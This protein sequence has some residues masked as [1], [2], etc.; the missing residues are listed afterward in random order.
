MIAIADNLCECGCGG[1]MTIAKYDDKGQ[2]YKAGKPRRFIHTHWQ[3]SQPKGP[4]DKHG[5]TQ[6]ER[7]KRS[8]S[9][10]HF[11]QELDDNVDSEVFYTM[12]RACW[13]EVTN[14]AISRLL[15]GVGRRE[16]VKRSVKPRSNC[17]VCGKELPK[18]RKR[19]CSDECKKIARLRHH[20]KLVRLKSAD[21]LLR[22]DFYNSTQREQLQL[23]FD[24]SRLVSE[25][26]VP[27]LIGA[28]WIAIKQAEKET[29]L[30]ELAK[31]VARQHW[32]AESNYAS[33]SLDAMKEATGFEAIAAEGD[34][35]R[36]GGR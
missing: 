9:I 4:R 33:K 22:I 35:Y 13:P 16:L 18:W 14:W 24:C 2:G 15:S 29:N 5:L 25:R 8:A 20:P 30:I 32:K 31:R 26:F 27:D 6:Y 7:L 34:R 28:M 17:Q 11:T 10:G 36:T 19:Y 23:A 21:E 3:R 12:I 1:R